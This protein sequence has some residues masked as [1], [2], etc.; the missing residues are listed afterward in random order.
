MTELLNIFDRPF[1]LSHTS[2]RDGEFKIGQTA[3][4]LSEEGDFTEALAGSK[5]K[6]AVLFIPE[7]IGIRA[8][9]GRPG[10]S[11]TWEYGLKGLCNLQDNYFLKGEDIL[12]LGAVESADLMSQATRLRADTPEGL[13]ELRNLTEELD[14]RVRDVLAS[15]FAAGLFP[16]VV[17]GGHNNVY[18]IMAGW[19]DTHDNVLSAINLDPHADYREMEGRHSG[20]G[21][22]YAH[23]Q[24]LL[25][26]YAVLGLHEGYNSAEMMHLLRQ[27]PDLRYTTFENIRVRRIVSFEQSLV[28]SLDFV[29]EE[30]FGIELDLDSI[31]GLPVSAATPTGF[32]LEEA[33][34]YMYRCASRE[35]ARY[36]HICEGSAGLAS[37]HQLAE[38]AKVI[39]SLIADTI[40]GHNESK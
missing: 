12:I 24:G 18:P 14:S 27:D 35:N 23:E 34:H 21:F 20:N 15:I 13:E 11:K 29:S 2:V 33:R 38:L 6:Y 19:Y 31:P 3:Q 25:D 28:D 39:A 5:A 37:T 30:N 10:A 8:N 4:I 26:R 22:R 17:G 1:I 32:T 16:I 40:K 7:D 36:A 9:C